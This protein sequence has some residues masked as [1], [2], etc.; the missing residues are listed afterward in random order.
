MVVVPTLSRWVTDSIAEFFAQAVHQNYINGHPFKYTTCTVAEIDGY[1]AVRNIAAQRFLA[2]PCDRLWF[3][4]NDTILPDDIFDLPYV[5]GDI[6]TLPYPFTGT[7]TPAIVNYANLWDF[8]HGLKDVVPDDDGIADV[9]G[10]GLGCTLIRRK[11]LEDPEM[12]YPTVYKTGDGKFLDEADDKDAPEPI[13]RFLRRPSGRWELG[14]DYDFCIRAKRLGYSIKIRMKSIC[15][16]LKTIDL[17]DAFERTR[18]AIMNER[19]DTR[20]YAL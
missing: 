7:M 10:T 3:I 20:T 6:V 4:D 1:A 13:F 14:E 16:H 17:N 12:R 18:A 5:D 11:V 2:S 19:Q 8:G 9:N 15:G